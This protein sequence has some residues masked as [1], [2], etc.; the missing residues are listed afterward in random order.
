[1]LKFMLNMFKKFF[2][3]INVLVILISL[4]LVVILSFGNFRMLFDDNCC[5]KKVLNF[6]FEHRFYFKPYLSEILI[7]TINSI[8]NY[9]IKVIISEL[10]IPILIYL[11]LF[12]IFAR[13][14]NTVWSLCFCLV[15]LVSFENIAFRHFLLQLFYNDS[16]LN[17]T[18]LDKVLAIQKFPLP[19]L[20][21]LFFLLIFDF[22][23]KLKKLT[24]TRISKVTVL[25][26]ILFYI[27]ALDAIF[28]FVFW[29]CYVFIRFVISKKIND[30]FFVLFIQIFITFL[31]LLPA[32]FFSNTT[33]ITDVAKV[34]I[35]IIEYQLIYMFLPLILMILIFF[36]F[37]IDKQEL[38]F[39]FL[40]IYSLM[41]SEFIIIYLAYFYNF[42]VDIE[43]LTK[44]VPLFFLHFLYY[45]PVLYFIINRKI[46]NTR[47]SYSNFKHNLENIIVF[48]I[49][50]LSVYILFLL[51]F[52]LIIFSYNIMV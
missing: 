48:S 49:N 26:S 34:S 2:Q 10:V 39:K 38:I 19:S 1:M 8:F 47:P 29:Y 18:S 35:N 16:S 20:S 42:G 3:E 24:V 52:F 44:R 28:G 31:T 5:D 50:K 7:N 36:I 12:K 14:S 23:I 41:I 13:Y 21:I 40:P 25:W 17:L 46:K 33:G 43:I 30:Y 9:E 22:S 27:N 11:M 37:K 15:S 32:L 45:L 51:T 6:Y 4:V